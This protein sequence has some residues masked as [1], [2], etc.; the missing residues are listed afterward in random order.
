VPVSQLVLFLAGSALA[1]IGIG[2]GLYYA[3]LRFVYHDPNS[4]Q[5][6][7]RVIFGRQSRSGASHDLI[8]PADGGPEVVPAA[9]EYPPPLVTVAV[10]T[11][12]PPA[13]QGSTCGDSMVRLLE[14]LEYN[15]KT[16]GEAPGESL[17]PLRTDAWNASRG[18]LRRLHPG[19]LNDLEMVYADVNLLNHL[20]WLATEFQ[21]HSPGLLQ[22]H[23]TLSASIAVRLDQ[24]MKGP[25][26]QVTAGPSEP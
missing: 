1:G 8:Q 2:L 13:A 25:L 23:A 7:Y 14:E 16:A 15:R 6:I 5:T 10:E 18:M 19:L 26:S 21:R 24:L 4:M 17:V 3:T 9:E 22:Q 11:P 12:A 20:V